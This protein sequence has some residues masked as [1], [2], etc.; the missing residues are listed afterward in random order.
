MRNKQ[1]YRRRG[2]LK[3][4]LIIALL[5]SQLATAG[6]ALAN[7][8]DDTVTDLV[9]YE[10]VP[11]VQPQFQPNSIQLSALHVYGAGHYTRAG[12]GLT[13][14]SSNT[15]IANVDA[16]G[17]VTLTGSHG[18]TVITV[19]DG[20]FSDRITIE[21]QAQAAVIK[22]KGARYDLIKRAVQGLTTQEKIG[23]M[24]MPDFRKYNGK[25]VTE[26]PPEVAA[27]VKQ[28]HLGG[29]LLFREN[30]VSAAQAAKLV[31][32]YQM[33]SDKF[34]L[35]ISIDQ[36]GG[37][38]TR[39]QTGT[40]FPGNMALGGTHS[41]E[42]AY[43]VG[44]S[45]GDELNA[46]GINWDFAPVLDTN[47]N[48]DNPVIGVRS[49]GGDPQLVA[50][51]GI[52]Y[53]RGLQSVGVAA[54][55]KHFPGHGD[56]AIDS[57][58]G[59]PSVPH[60]K[61]RLKEVEL[62]PFQKAMEN[63]IDAIMTAHV[64]F[65]QIDSTTAIS[66]KDGNPVNMPATLS[67]KVLTELVR[68]E[69]GFQGVIS[70]DAMNMQAIVDHFG[71]ADAAIR[72][73]NAGADIILMPVGLQTVAE[74]LL[75]AVQSGEITQERLNLSVERILT[76]KMKRGVFK[77]EQPRD[78]NERI[79]EANRV[80]GS[81]EHRAWDAEVSRRAVTL[82]KNDHNIIPLKL[83]SAQKVVVVGNTSITALFNAVKA[84]HSNTTLVSTTSYVLTTA[85][86]NELQSAD[87]V[88]IGTSTSTAS[89]RATS[90]AQMKM[91]RDIKGAVTA[92][93]IAV[94]L[95]NPYD[96]MGY[97]DHVDAYV[98]Q[99]SYFAN[100][101]QGSAD[102]IF[103]L[104]N[105]VGK[106]PVTIPSY[107]GGVLY[108][109]NHGLRTTT[110]TALN[111]ASSV[112]GGMSFD[113]TYGLEGVKDSIYAQDFTIRYDA[114]KVQFIA[115]ESLNEGFKVAAQ[116]EAPGQ[117]RFITASLG[118]SNSVNGSAQ[119]LKLTWRAKT[120]SG[121]TS[122][123]VSD[124]V[125][126][127][128]SGQE[129][130]AVGASHAVYMSTIDKTALN[131]L[132]AESQEVHDQA[133]EGSQV[134]QYPV[135]SKAKLQAAIDKATATA[136]REAATSYEV[137]QAIQ[138]LSAALQTFID[139]VHIGIPGD[140][141]GDDKVSIGDLAFTAR[142]YGAT[143]ADPNWHKVRGA[144]FNGNGQIDIQDLAVIARKILDS[145]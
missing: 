21:L 96:I 75:A 138:Q 38:V 86:L 63:G 120:S 10:N 121:W 66:K 91:V 95:R 114:D 122:I 36:E 56:T 22:E 83:N 139:S 113:L 51:L 30:A 42:L 41:A 58:L 80:V 24:L 26:L 89:A 68:E 62:Y 67:Y 15:Q 130:A 84:N 28:Y 123:S 145:P 129:A 46:L 81:A 52:A 43:Q 132:I 104:R 47:N 116:K 29:I 85:Q 72:A 109:Y 11:Q 118:E 45:I 65:P 90:N 18:T 33:A 126:S 107:E 87:A 23:Q 55:A 88:I 1:R 136:N 49:F 4:V 59:L 141:N 117:I 40:N 78:I 94:A 37:I 54:T 32:D 134:G 79:E 92:P 44:K 2:L 25:N 60:S 140:M 133:Q 108:P 9:I 100:S 101:S 105:P 124:A 8:A 69:M 31:H 76:L 70:T 73:V 112:I 128:A 110:S 61:E 3:L 127:N 115:A 5:L 71:P 16:G 17:L 142:Y 106:L 7:P 50:D 48:P 53:I 77:E 135:G 119:L 98:A 13:W 14:E 144:D 27:L 111:G 35:L 131:R 39:L 64:T 19:R 20:I 93:V 103:G 125:V 12:S 57:H 74:G 6:A 137:E 82:I 143:S 102:V 99:Y 97:P 34:G